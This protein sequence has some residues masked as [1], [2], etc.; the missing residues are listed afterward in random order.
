MVIEVFGAA[1]QTHPPVEPARGLWPLMCI[2]SNASC[3]RPDGP[4]SRCRPARARA[5]MHGAQPERFFWDSRTRAASTARSSGVGS[6]GSSSGEAIGF[7][8]QIRYAYGLDRQPPQ[9]GDACT[10]TDCVTKFRFANRARLDWPFRGLRPRWVLVI[11]GDSRWQ[12]LRYGSCR[13]RGDHDFKPH[14]PMSF[15]YSP[16]AG[17]GW[18]ETARIRSAPKGTS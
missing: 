10:T 5:A 12:S 14:L 13:V 4:E 16:A 3:T 6:T 8:D 18:V 7:L 17:R 2:R 1:A 15:G 9:P 11:G